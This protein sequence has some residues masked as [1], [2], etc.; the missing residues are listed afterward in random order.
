MMKDFF[1]AKNQRE[2]SLKPFLSDGF[3][4]VRNDQAPFLT[5]LYSSFGFPLSPPS[6]DVKLMN[7]SL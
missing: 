1:M 6:V 5:S 2:W 3:R 7:L 4:I